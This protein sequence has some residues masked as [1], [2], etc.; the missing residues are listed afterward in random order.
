MIKDIFGYE[1]ELKDLIQNE[2]SDIG[3]ENKE[4][5]CNFIN[6]NYKGKEQYV[7]LG[8]NCWF[9]TINKKGKIR[10]RMCKKDK[11]SVLMKAL[12]CL[13]TGQYKVFSVNN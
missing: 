10:M 12:E 3:H 13:I 1:I 5:L 11:Q 2:I 8:G 4:L 9:K 7:S 6:F